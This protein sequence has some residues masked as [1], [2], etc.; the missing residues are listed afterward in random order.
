MTIKEQAEMQTPDAPS[1]ELQNQT[2]MNNRTPLY[3]P[4][5]LIIFF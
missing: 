3:S 4:L 2:Q 5:Y 1:T